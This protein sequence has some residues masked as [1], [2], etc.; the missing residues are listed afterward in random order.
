MSKYMNDFT[1]KRAFNDFIKGLEFE[2]K[3]KQKYRDLVPTNILSCSGL[4]SQADP[5][6]FEEHQKKHNNYKGLK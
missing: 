2:E 1:S 4:M 5:D 3:R 6:A